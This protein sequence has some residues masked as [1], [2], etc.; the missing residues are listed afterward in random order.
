MR[1]LAMVLAALVISC[2]GETPEQ[3][4]PDTGATKDVA[5]VGQETG[6]G[7]TGP[8]CDGSLFCRDYDTSAHDCSGDVGACDQWNKCWQFTCALMEQKGGIE[9]S[10]C[11]GEVEETYNVGD[12]YDYCHEKENADLSRNDCAPIGEYAPCNEASQ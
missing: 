12:L 4:D 10:A 8:V 2:G 5:D 9:R 11:L 7:D 6:G 1:Y 3:G